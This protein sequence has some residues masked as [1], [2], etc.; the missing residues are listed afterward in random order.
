[1]ACSSQLSFQLMFPSG[2]NAYAYMVF[3]IRKLEVW[4]TVQVL[5]LELETITCDMVWRG[6][7]P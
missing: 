2:V 6:L 4:E 5:V 3:I 7:V 1:M